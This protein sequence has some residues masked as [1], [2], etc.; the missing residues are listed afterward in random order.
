MNEQK[1]VKKENTLA[2]IG[3]LALVF[4]AGG[5][6]PGQALELHTSE[7]T[8]VF[9]KETMTATE[10]VR[11][12]QSLKTLAADLVVC[13]AKACGPCDSCKDGCPYLKEAEEGGSE[14]QLPE[15]LLEQAGIPKDAK[16]NVFAEDG[17]I[18]ITEAGPDLRDVPSDLL[19]LFQQ[20]GL[21]LGALD[22]LLVEGGIIYGG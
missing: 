8:A 22:E 6:K 16:M 15:A 4:T 13:L 3:T 14:L 9:L 11:S 12:I 5:M 10:L 17:E 2:S 19:E 7:D 18:H 20:T 1:V 21:C